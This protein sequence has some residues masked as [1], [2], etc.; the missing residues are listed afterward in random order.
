MMLRW[1]GSCGF[2]WRDASYSGALSK[3]NRFERGASYSRVLCKWNR[4][5]RGRFAFKGT[6]RGEPFRVSFSFL[7]SCETLLLLI[8]REF[9]TVGCTFRCSPINRS[10][11]TSVPCA[12]RKFLHFLSR[13]MK[14]EEDGYSMLCCLYWDPLDVFRSAS[15]SASMW[16]LCFS[17]VS[18]LWELCYS[19]ALG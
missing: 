7:K 12:F 5:E 16:E 17:L 14:F 6:L 9:L 18:P 13:W 19:L 4:F 1:Y 15:L 11:V 3:W 8:N 10:F 2:V